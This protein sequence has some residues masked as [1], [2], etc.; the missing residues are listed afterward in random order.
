MTPLLAMHSLGHGLMDL[1]G[2]E[3][4]LN[5][6]LHDYALPEEEIRKNLKALEGYPL[7]Q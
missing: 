6:E 5:G 1:V 7:P 3:K 4:F 2:Y